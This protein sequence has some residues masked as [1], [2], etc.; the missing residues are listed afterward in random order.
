[1]V[2]VFFIVGLLMNKWPF[3]L[4]AMTCCIILAATKVLTIKQAF[5]GFSNKTLIMIACMYVLSAAFGKT[6]L[7]AKMQSWLF[8]LSGKGDTYCF[9][10]F[11][12]FS[13]FS[14]AFFPAVLLSR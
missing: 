3:G 14:P 13:F 4:T 5:A 1:M 11:S 10:G 8:D 9:L 2:L 7:L 12:E 6:A